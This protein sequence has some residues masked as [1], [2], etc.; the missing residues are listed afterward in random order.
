MLIRL[1]SESK[2][3]SD[4]SRTLISSSLPVQTGNRIG[5]PCQTGKAAIFELIEH[6][7]N[8]PV[9]DL[10]QNRCQRLRSTIVVRVNIIGRNAGCR[11][12]PGGVKPQHRI[13]VEDIQGIKVKC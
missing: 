5:S 9:Q 4:G 13:L 6:G 12:I 11:S 7:S 1:E 8:L 10:I 2:S 3:K